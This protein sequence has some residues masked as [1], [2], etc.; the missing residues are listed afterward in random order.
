MLAAGDFLAT[1][2]FFAAGL[3]RVAAF[4]RAGAVAAVPLPPGF[5]LSGIEAAL[6]RARAPGRALAGV[7]LAVLRL[8][9]FRSPV[10]FARA[11]APVPDFACFSLFFC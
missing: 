4:F 3:L 2:G 9:G 10:A 5:A 1:A 11:A 8:A 6:A 7:F